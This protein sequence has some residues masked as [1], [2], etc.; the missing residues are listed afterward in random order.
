MRKHLK[1]L[2]DY[3]EALDALGDLRTVGQ[4]ADTHLEIG[5]VIRRAVETC[6]PAPLFT[7][8]RG[9]APGFRVL[10]APAAFSSLPGARW[11]RAALSLGLDPATHPLELVEELAA[12]R[13]LDP[14]APVT[15][16]SGE[17]QQN[18]LLG[19]DASL[20]AFPIPLI[21][22]G[23]GGRYVNTWG[24]IVV[25]TPDGTW[26]NWSIA[27]VMMVD[28]HTMTGM[29]RPLQD[30][31][32]IFAMWRERGEPM[33]FALAQGCAPAIPFV[34]GM[35][36]PSGLDEA[37]YLG[38]HFG[39]PLEVVRCRTVGLTVPATAEIV[40]EGH[41]AVDETAPE[42]PMGEYF[43]YL[44]GGSR[45]WPVFRIG[46]ITH[47]DDPILP[48]VSAGK[49]VEEDHT[50]VGLTYSAEALVSLRAAGL[51][52]TGA[53]IVPESA[54]NVLA[55]TVS[56]DWARQGVFTSTRMLCRA[57]AQ[58]VLRPKVGY[59]ITRIMVFDDD[60]DPT[61]TRDVIWAY[62]TRCH[63]VR[64][65]LLVEDQRVTPLHIFYSPEEQGVGGP[66]MVYDCLLPPDGPQRPRS[67]AFAENF[68]PAVQRRALHLW[69]GALKGT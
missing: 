59:W 23:D 60:I 42:G 13:R 31:G 6:G 56:R 25:R 33:P 66:K 58:A 43:G 8:I 30:L 27:R 40:I 64:G 26:T 46:A 36:L 45:P 19:D 29:I 61:D 3:L 68:A 39:E 53:W 55:V 57:V 47:R 18:V 69:E 49:P 54:V 15:V 11:S 28:D 24:T 17:C 2:R 41:V 4:E 21:H 32:K 1:S 5:A 48:V 7:A 67:T 62:A 9:H 22:D 12:A 16:D 20:A 63:P 65:Q 51:P 10:G 35:G 50:V 38:A 37:G 44:G 14:I 34:C 52:V